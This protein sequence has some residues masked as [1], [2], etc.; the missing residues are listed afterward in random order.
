MVSKK[1]KISL[2]F[3]VLLFSKAMC[4][5]IDIKDFSLIVVGNQTEMNSMTTAMVRE[6]F[7]GKNFVPLCEPSQK[8]CLE[9]TPQVHQK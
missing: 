3:W 4:A 6:Y 9:L 1:L 8:G 5:Q 2:L 7:K